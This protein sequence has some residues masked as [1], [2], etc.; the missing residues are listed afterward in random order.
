MVAISVDCGEGSALNVLVDGSARKVGLSSPAITT[1]VNCAPLSWCFAELDAV[2][3]CCGCSFRDATWPSAKDP[4]AMPFRSMSLLAA[5]LLNRR[6]WLMYWTHPQRM[7]RVTIPELSMIKNST[8]TGTF[9]ESPPSCITGGG[10]GCVPAAT[11]AAVWDICWV[12]CCYLNRGRSKSSSPQQFDCRLGALHLWRKSGT[13]FVI[14]WIVTKS[15]KSKERSHDEIAALN[16]L[17]INK[18]SVKC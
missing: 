3:G 14:R 6:L 13:I 4:L 5:V 11:A 16:L 2:R 18:L 12:C 8:Y 1:Y 15:Y 10:P 9:R 17:I 7:S